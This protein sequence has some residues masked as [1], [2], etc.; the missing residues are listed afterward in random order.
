MFEG[1]GRKEVTPPGGAA[2]S[3]APAQLKPEGYVSRL[4]F[5]LPAPTL[6][7]SFY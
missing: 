6:G 4:A 1:R 3:S 2:A 7:D 5:R